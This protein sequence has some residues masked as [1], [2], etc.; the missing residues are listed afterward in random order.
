MDM[1]ES[2]EAEPEPGASRRSF[3]R[4]AG[5]VAGGLVGSSALLSACTPGKNKSADAVPAS[6]ASGAGAAGGALT[7]FSAYD[8]LVRTKT[9]GRTIKLGF[10]PTFLAEFFTQIEGAMFQRM[11]ELETAYGVKWAYKRQT[12]AQNSFNSTQ[13]LIQIIQNLASQKYDALVVDSGGD[14]ATMENAYR[15]ALKSG[16]KCFQINM[17]PEMHFDKEDRF[18]FQSS[19][20]YDNKFQAGFVVGDYIGQTLKGSGTVMQIWGPPGSEFADARQTGFDAALAKYPGLKVVAKGN[21]QY[22]RNTGFTV[23]Q[24]LLTRYPNVNAIYGENDDMALGAA[25]AVD[26]RGLKH[27]DGQK[28]VVIVGADGLLSGMKAIRDGKLTASVDV[29]TVDIGRYVIDDV[30]HSV[31]LGDAV[32]KL[33]WVP[34]RLVTKENVDIPEAY[35]KWSLKPAKKY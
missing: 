30:F 22:Q 20:G 11:Y 7:G 8:D 13:A 24:D 25:Q 28:G 12:P 19:V 18:V 14:F 16:T 35:M 10:T 27:W 33:H 34:T 9:A 15:D 6:A 23:T 2:P 1:N 17:V 26:A 29:N 4:G 32:P 3:L 5:L 21:G 31:I